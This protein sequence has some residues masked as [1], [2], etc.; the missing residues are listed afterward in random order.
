MFMKERIQVYPS[1]VKKASSPPKTTREQREASK[2]YSSAAIEFVR[3]QI[4]ILKPYELSQSQ[5]NRTYQLMMNDDAIATCFIARTMAVAKAQA[6]G[7]FQYNINSPESVKLKEFFEY[8]MKN[9]VGQSPLTIG[10]AA[11]H[12]IRD[13]WSPFEMVFEDGEDRWQGLW[14]LKKLAYIHPMSLDTLKPWEV[15]AGGDKIT[16]LRQKPDAFY[17]SNGRSVGSQNTY[18]NGVREIK[19]NRV[20]YSSYAATNT[21]P[22][23]NSL[24]DA[25][26]IPWKEKQLLQDL[27]LVGVQKDLAGMP[28]LGA[29]SD[30]LSKAAEDPSSTEAGMVEQLKNNLANLHA[31]DQAFSII[32]T[33]THSDNGSG[34]RQFELK[35]LGIEGGS[36]AFDVVEL[37]EQRKRSIFNVFSCQNMISGE[38]GGGSYNLLEGQ[39]SIQAH[40]VELDNM[41][42][43][44]MF[45]RQV[46]RKLMLLNGMKPANEADIPIWKSGDVQEI[47]MDEYGKYINRV[48]RLIPAHADVVN[49]ILAK[50]KV[51]HRLSHD[52]TPDDIRE[53]LFTF[54]DPS[55]TGTSEGSSGQGDSQSG[56]A[57]SDTNAENAS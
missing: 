22:I 13:G 31:G 54:E 19:F 43:D 46:F 23:G 25:A 56:G 44:D 38:N 55:K 12:M 18:P 57:S 37:V 27:T 34:Q 5:R 51:N 40:A 53:M 48:A 35:F 21:Q 41:V 8:N 17:G 29:P 20:A 10:M 52:A 36:K 4:N 47:S 24:F 16:V 6:R 11:S 45:N 33:D 32:P 49:A 3:K 1:G 14:K 15:A 30:L 50:M 2:Q 26:Y 28:V 7:S 9:L 39:S 42:I